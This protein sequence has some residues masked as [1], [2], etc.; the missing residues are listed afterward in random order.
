MIIRDTQVPGNKVSLPS[1][2]VNESTGIGETALNSNQRDQFNTQLCRNTRSGV[3]QYFTQH[4]AAF[5]VC[6]LL[7][8]T[9]N[10]E[11]D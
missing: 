10:K 8:E 1:H 5:F 11:I 4:M 9:K 6:P 3:Y 2:Q 7:Q